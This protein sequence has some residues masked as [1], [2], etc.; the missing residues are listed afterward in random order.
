MLRAAAMRM[1]LLW[2]CCGDWASSV[3]DDEDDDVGKDEEEREI[4]KATRVFAIR[5]R[6]FSGSDSADD[7]MKRTR[8]GN[9]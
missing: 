3:N 7:S 6:A 2:N 1:L 4:A 8:R 5:D 9:R